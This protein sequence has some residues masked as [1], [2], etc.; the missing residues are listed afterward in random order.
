MNFKR[1]LLIWVV[2]M[3]GVAIST[4]MVLGLKDRM[5]LQQRDAQTKRVLQLTQ[6]ELNKR[7]WATPKGEILSQLPRGWDKIYDELPFRVLQNGKI[8]DGWNH[9]IRVQWRIPDQPEIELRSA[10]PD[11]LYDTDDDLVYVVEQKFY[12]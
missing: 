7:L 9:P 1:H 2:G 8:Y 12:R 5:D 3:G 6:E 4:F 10:G 11:G